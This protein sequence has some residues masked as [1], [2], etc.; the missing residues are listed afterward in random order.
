MGQADLA[1][2]R[3]TPR[4][5][6]APADPATLRLTRQEARHDDR[7]PPPHPRAGYPTGTVDGATDNVAI[8]T[9]PTATAA[10]GTVTHVAVYDALTAGNMLKHGPLAASRVVASGDT[11]QIAVGALDIAFN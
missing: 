4:T 2:A 1:F 8:I 11:F 9:F 3:V 5:F 6:R 10:W 7:H